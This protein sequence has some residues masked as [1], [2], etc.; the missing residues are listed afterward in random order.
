M[1]AEMTSIW[2]AHNEIHSS[3]GSNDNGLF[4][5][6]CF[7]R[8]SHQELALECLDFLGLRSD[9][10]YRHGNWRVHSSVE[11]FFLIAEAKRCLYALLYGMFWLVPR[12]PAGIQHIPGVWFGIH[13]HV[14]HRRTSHVCPSVFPFINLYV[15]LSG[16]VYVSTCVR[17][18]SETL[19]VLWIMCADFNSRQCF[20]LK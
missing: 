13:T 9:E 6:A 18:F 7:C 14:G 20:V 19:C 5:D 8:D 16:L 2:L 3:S 1:N 10:N 15:C 12:F 11:T 17:R 4:R